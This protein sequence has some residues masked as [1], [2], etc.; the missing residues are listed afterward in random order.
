V[1]E[2]AHGVSSLCKRQV[3]GAQTSEDPERAERA[4]DRVSALDADHRSDAA[5]V[6]DPLHVVRGP[7]EL[8]TGRM[9][10]Y[11]L[12]EH[13]DLLERLR[14]RFVCREM[15]GYVDRPELRAE[16]AGA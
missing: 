6:C 1:A 5:S 9:L 2:S 11:Q 10:A 15:R 3:A 4:A 7:R 14:H 8:E 13:V 12:V 16:L